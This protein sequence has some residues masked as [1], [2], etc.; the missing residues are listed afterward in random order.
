MT[1]WWWGVVAG[2]AIGYGAVG[3]LLITAPWVWLG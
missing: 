3:Y 2:I 1:A